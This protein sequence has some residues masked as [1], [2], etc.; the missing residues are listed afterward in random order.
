MVNMAT[1]FHQE[2]A[3][4]L[5]LLALGTL[6]LNVS[7]RTRVFAVSLVAVAPI[8]GMVLLT[9]RR[10][11]SRLRRVAARPQA[12]GDPAGTGGDPAGTGPALAA[13][14]RS[15]TH[16]E[17]ND[18]RTAEDVIDLVRMDDDGG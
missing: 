12:G 14:A 7:T 17:A 4:P 8:A 11:A 18:P 9:A 15:R 16:G 13:G 2:L 3:I 1:V 5:W 6:G 10:R